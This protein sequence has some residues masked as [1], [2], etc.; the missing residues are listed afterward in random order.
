MMKCEGKTVAAVPLVEVLRGGE[1]ESVHCGHFVVANAA[2]EIVDGA[3]DPQLVTFPR[4]SL[5]LIQSIGLLESGAADRF[6]L[7]NTH[8][9]MACASHRGE[10][11]HIELIS[12]W[13]QRIDCNMDD[14]ACGPDYPL[15]PE[16][17]ERAIAAGGGRRRIYHNCSGKHTGFLTLCRHLNVD[18]AGYDTLAHPS[19]QR[20]LDDLSLFARLDARELAWGIDGCTL[21]APAM[22]L[23]A[24][25][26]AMARFSVALGV[27]TAKREAITR[28]QEAIAAAPEYLSG[29]GHV[30]AVLARMTDGQVICKSGAEGYFIAV[31]RDRGL[32]VALKIAD[33]ASRAS[34]V[35]ICAVLQR[36][37]VLGAGHADQIQAL[38]SPPVLDSRGRSAGVLRPSAATFAD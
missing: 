26:R 18:P 6:R 10:P 9:A 12:E 38:L 37:G 27:G 1:L 14:L 25:A 20:Y 31:V 23:D 13:L 19:Q 16:A 22:A 33:G 24:M 30:A 17:A 35:A 11:F 34:M 7:D 4:S 15:N 8:I 5:K 32:G 21:P 29:T 28:I 3:G 2:G 36:I